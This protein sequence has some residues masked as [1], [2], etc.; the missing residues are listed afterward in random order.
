MTAEAMRPERT[1]IRPAPRARG[2]AQGGRAVLASGKLHLA[3]TATL[4]QDSYQKLL[5]HLYGT[6]EQAPALGSRPLIGAARLRA[7]RAQS[8]RHPAR[9]WPHQIKGIVLDEIGTPRS[10]Q[11]ARECPLQGSF[12]AL[13][14]PVGRLG[15]VLVQTWDRPPSFSTMHRPASPESRVIVILDGTTVEEVEKVHLDTLKLS[16]TRSTRTSPS[17]RPDSVG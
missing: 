3:T 6:R 4:T 12:P 17:T 10:D 7:D 9:G 8:L 11:N 5:D 15:T 16:S 2:R 13:A 14:S 1:E